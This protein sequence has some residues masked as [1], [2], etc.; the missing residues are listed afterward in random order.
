MDKFLDFRVW[1]IGEREERPANTNVRAR[2]AG[3]AALMQLAKIDEEGRSFP[4]EYA[5]ESLD[6]CL[7]VYRVAQTII[8]A[9]VR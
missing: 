5:V 2:N 3:D 9:R 6:G 8:T 4:Y 7:E 1:D